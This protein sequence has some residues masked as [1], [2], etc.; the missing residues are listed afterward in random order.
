MLKIVPPFK[1]PRQEQHDRIF[2]ED[3]INRYKNRL[4]TAAGYIFTIVKIYRQQGHKLTIPKPR[5]FYEQFGIPK[6]T[7]YRALVQLEKA[8]GI[9]FRWEPVG[10]ISMW[11]GEEP[12]TESS[13][14][15]APEVELKCQRLNQ[16]PGEV[17]TKFEAFVRSEWRKQKGQEIRSFH[18]FVEKPADF[19]NWWQKFQA[20]PKLQVAAEVITETE[21]AIADSVEPQPQPVS[22]DKFKALASFIRRPK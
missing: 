2:L 21:F 11:W 22:R 1:L 8:D 20:L 16:L 13:L 18:R 6:S 15:I 9:K 14:A 19:Q 12:P 4:L 5:A 10:G 7:F 17:R 3:A